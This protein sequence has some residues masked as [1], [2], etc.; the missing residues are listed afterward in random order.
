MIFEK[1]KIYDILEQTVA[2]LEAKSANLSDP[3]SVFKYIGFIRKS[4][5][6]A[7]YGQRY[8]RPL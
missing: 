8:F 3:V 7:K 1:Q 6:N 2:D 4:Q 5:E